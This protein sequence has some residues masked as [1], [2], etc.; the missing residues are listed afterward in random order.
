MQIILVL[1]ALLFPSVSSAQAI[2]G[3]DHKCVSESIRRCMGNFA[4]HKSSDTCPAGTLPVPVGSGDA[5]G[6]N[7][8]SLLRPTEKEQVQG[9]IVT[10]RNKAIVTSGQPLS[11]AEELVR[12]EW[13]EKIVLYT[14][15]EG[16]GCLRG[17]PS[18]EHFDSFNKAFLDKFKDALEKAFPPK[19]AESAASATQ[20]AA[21]VKP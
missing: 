10:K 6:G 9:G 18:A 8:I 1:M 16:E 7:C 11:Y 19:S 15:A 13:C 20:S 4:G 14:L 21:P 17:M 2:T 3:L 5:A 12:F